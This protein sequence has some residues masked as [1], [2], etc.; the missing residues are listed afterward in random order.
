[1]RFRNL[2]VIGPIR[3]NFRLVMLVT[4]GVSILAIGSGSF[5]A[6]EPILEPVQNSMWKRRIRRLK[7]ADPESTEEMLVSTGSACGSGFSHECRG[8]I[9][10]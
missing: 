4:L 1:M 10:G 8:I 2:A 6:I 3:K 9:R 7:L 5:A